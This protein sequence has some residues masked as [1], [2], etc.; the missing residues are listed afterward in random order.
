MLRV[1]PLGVS[2]LMCETLD[3]MTGS[4]WYAWFSLM[5]YPYHVAPAK[6]ARK[7]S[8]L[9]YDTEIFGYDLFIHSF[10]SAIR[11]LFW[12]F[13]MCLSLTLYFSSFYFIF[14]YYIFFILFPLFSFYF[15][16][17]DKA[18]CIYLPCPKPGEFCEDL[19]GS[20][21]CACS[22]RHQR[23][24]EDGPCLKC[25]ST[26]CPEGKNCIHYF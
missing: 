16:Y 2:Y 20:F 26:M 11:A 13:L 9:G 4:L 12:T 23:V 21:R 19:L 8:V 18:E 17:L 1:L 6:I 3:G 7:I 15:I 10:D 25:S 14:F 22:P 5:R 24:G